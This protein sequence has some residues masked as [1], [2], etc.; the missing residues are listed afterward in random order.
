MKKILVIFVLLVSLFGCKK[1][2]TVVD[3]NYS[4][5][6]IV[7]PT[8][9]PSLA[10]INSIDDPTF[11]TNSNISNIVSMLTSSSDKRIV[12]ID[13]ISGIKAIKKGAP[14][15]LAA[16]ITFGNFY[17]ASTGN[18]ENGLMGEEDNI[19]LFGKNTTPDLI[20]HYIYGNKFDNSIEYVNAVSD[21]GKCLAAGKN[22]ETGNS[23]DYVMI[24]EPVLSTILANK[25]TPTYGSAS[26]FV[27]IQEEYKKISGEEMIQASIFVKDDGYIKDAEDYFYYL[28]SNINKILNDKE[29]VDECLKTKSDEEITSV[30]G[31][32]RKMIANALSTNSIGLGFKKAYENKDAIDAF[33]K[34][35]DLEE[36]DEEIYFK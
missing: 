14:F 27:N 22:L 29:F 20:F 25:E 15:K 2:E 33:I 34:I 1:V 36:T 32:N 10:F 26:I 3:Y 18:D 23:V 12:V 11:E 35:F 30:F 5:M 19:V 7:T 17:I 4:N 21:A 9:A 13:T 24:A 31:I 28:D 16:N 8:G 6:G